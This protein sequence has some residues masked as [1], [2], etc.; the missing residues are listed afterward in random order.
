MKQ[1]DIIT[2]NIT[3]YGSNGEGI[4]R[5]DGCVV[6]VP[7]AVKGERIRAKVKFV[8]KSFANAELIAVEETSPLRVNP[9]CNRFTR[10]GGCHIM[11]IDYSEQLK[12]KR[13]AL[14]NTL[15]KNYKASF[16]VDDCVPSPKVYGYRNK[17]MLPFGI[18]NGRAALGFYSEGTH[19]VVSITKC[20]L[21]GDWAERLISAALEYANSNA[22]SVYD[23]QS[24]KGI[25]RHLVARYIDGKIAIAVV[26][27]ADKLPR[28]DRLMELLAKQFEEY[29]LYISVNR[30]ANNVIMG[31]TVELL[32]GKPMTATING[33]SYE[34]NPL[35][36]L[37]VNNEVRDAIYN[38]II[39]EVL[40]YGSGAVIDAYAGVGL[41]GAMIAKRN[42]PVYNIEIVPEATADADKLAKL[43]N[44][45]P[46][47]T[48]ICGDAAVEL[49]KLVKELRNTYPSITIILDPPRKGCAAEVIAT[50][51]E[52]AAHNG[53]NINSDS[54]GEDNKN[55]VAPS[56]IDNGKADFATHTD[57]DKTQLNLAMPSVLK[58][59]P[60][61]IEAEKASVHKFVKKPDID[62]GNSNTYNDNQGENNTKEKQNSLITIIYISCNPATLAR[63]L[64]LLSANYQVTSIT[65]YDMFPN[66][67]H[68][69]TL[70]CL[71]KQ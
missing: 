33:I 43:N 44:I 9:P 52:I 23:E 58:N 12:L 63:D 53:N 7:F 26:I 56:D 18:V 27:N 54:I 2:L 22:I 30:N 5:H 47:V 69:E 66:T 3:D 45:S 46:L 57:G 60:I 67:F 59:S 34:L 35:S 6:F 40:E 71:T 68:I 16:T 19:R 64:A 25:L 17:I 61:D 55:L 50:L 20:F 42:I 24:G 41:L 29:S 48:N 70:V 37:Q 13:D 32:C 21:N 8:K 62:N 14:I 49:P 38:K 51:N 4:A 31:D 39:Q 65:P 36:F 11:H 10:C 28:V 1:G 15:R